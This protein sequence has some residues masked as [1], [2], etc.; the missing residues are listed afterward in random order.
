[1]LRSRHV[2]E[3]GRLLEVVDSKSVG[4]AGRLRDVLP[5][6]P[7][8]VATV[9]HLKHYSDSNAFTRTW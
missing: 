3:N 1:M 5:G 2:P 8:E 4:A 6:L 9:W 7:F